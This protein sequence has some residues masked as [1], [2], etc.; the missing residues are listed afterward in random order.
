MAG[1]SDLGF[2]TLARRYGAGLTYT[3]MVS[4]CGLMYRNKQTE[5]LT[6]VA[7]CETPCAIQLFGSDP[8]VFYKAARHDAVAKFDIID[9]NMGC[10]VHKVVSRGEG[11]ALMKTPD[12]AMDIVRATIEG[13]GGKPVT[14]KMRA[15]WDK[16]TA[17]DFAC[18]MQEAG[19]S[20]VTVHGRT[21]AQLYTGKADWTVIRAV[22]DAVDIPVIANGDVKTVEDYHAIKEA[23]GAT[24]VMIAR[25]AVGHTSLFAEIRGETPEVDLRADF[26]LQLALLRETFSDHVACML[27]KPHLIAAVSGRRNAKELRLAVG[28][29]RTIE[30]IEDIIRAL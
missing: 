12:R 15:G 10:P 4:V 26:T 21:R 13:S 7:P 11:S 8:E 20:L 25:G 9:I 2:R 19:A 29:A 16:P 28:M 30:E 27:L 1:V 17:P 23:T 14:V 18:Q 3:E 24:G 6:A 22:V 5:V